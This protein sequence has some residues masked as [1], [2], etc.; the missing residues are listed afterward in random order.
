MKDNKDFDGSKIDGAE[1][2]L[3]SSSPFLRKLENFWYYHKWKILI[4]AFFALVLGICIGQMAGREEV[5]DTVVVAVPMSLYAEQIEG[6]DEVLTSLM[7]AG[8]KGSKNLVLQIY[9]IYSEAELKEVN[10]QETDEEG[11]YV[12][13]V[14]QSYNTSKIEEYHDY[15]NTGASSLLI[16]SPYLY[17]PQAEY[18]R[19]LPLS[20]VFGDKL[21]AGALADGYG[22]RLG[23]TYAY[24]YFEA[25]QALPP[26]TVICLRRQP[27]FGLA[28]KD[29]QYERTKELFRSLVTFGN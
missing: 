13:R 29:A 28:S 8:E 9:P 20:Q 25:L 11:H 24:S 21:P 2:E 6:V 5:D 4:V 3:T 1:I 12:I 17:D 26:D 15:I 27:V 10:E 7:P 22:V 14:L 16:L 19:L 23:D 18:D